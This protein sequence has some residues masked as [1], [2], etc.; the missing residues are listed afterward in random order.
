M[1]MPPLLRQT[2]FLVY[3]ATEGSCWYYDGSKWSRD[4]AKTWRDP[5][6]RQGDRDPAVCVAW[7]DAK[8]YLNWLGAKTGARYRL[9]SEAEWEYVARAGGTAPYPSGSAKAGISDASFKSM[10]MITPR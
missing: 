8:A 3:Y 7:T 10:I 6:F 4:N 5:G 2:N 9:P 1:A